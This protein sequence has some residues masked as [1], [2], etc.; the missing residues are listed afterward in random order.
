[1]FFFTSRM[2]ASNVL[3][4]FLFLGLGTYY[5]IYHDQS[6]V[7]CFLKRRT[8]VTVCLCVITFGPAIRHLST[9]EDIVYMCML[10]ILVHALRVHFCIVYTFPQCTCP[11]RVHLSIQIT[12]VHLVYTCPHRVHLSIQSTLVHTEYTCP[13]RVHLS[14]QSTLVHTEYT[15]PYRVHL[16]T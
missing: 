12:L 7:I 9:Q 6:K 1:M 14:I 10:G 8:S 4:I 16:S 2:S 5:T 3:K 13:Y 11:H 15:C